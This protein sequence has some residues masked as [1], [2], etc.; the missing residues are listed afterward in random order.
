MHDG[1]HI[2]TRIQD[3]AQLGLKCKAEFIQKM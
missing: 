3:A 2:Q 1:I